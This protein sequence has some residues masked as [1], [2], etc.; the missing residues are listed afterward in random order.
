[1]RNKIFKNLFKTFLVIAITI[2]LSLPACIT[3]GQIALAQ[4]T[5]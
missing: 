1:V 3:G 4:T 2:F 5:P